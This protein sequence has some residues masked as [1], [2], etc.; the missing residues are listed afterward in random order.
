[1]YPGHEVDEEVK[2]EVRERPLS[3]VF[4]IV[5]G[6]LGFWFFM[7]G[8]EVG[9][10]ICAL[11]M[12]LGYLGRGVVTPTSGRSGG[13]LGYFGIGIGLVG[14]LINFIFNG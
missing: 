10:I 1:M 2:D 5:F 3:A 8:P 4:S 6:M 13:N 7:F 12:V 11:A 14:F 9:M